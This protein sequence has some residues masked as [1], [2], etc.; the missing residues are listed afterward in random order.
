M[1]RPQK[2]RRIEQL[3][4]VTHYKPAGIPLREIKEI[5][6]TFEEMEAI[7]LADVEHLDQAGAAQRMEI[8][9]PTFNR[10][11]NGAHEKIAS[12]LWQ[13]CALRVEGGNF[14]IARCCHHQELRDFICHACGHHWSLPHGT[15]QRCHDVVCPQCHSADISRQQE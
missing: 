6:L 4:P 5:I 1:V 8:S 7:R 3:P 13:G 10:I 14:R 15:G 12:A 11:V 2:E 9:P